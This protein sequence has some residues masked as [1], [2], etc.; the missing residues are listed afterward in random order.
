MDA[1]CKNGLKAT[2]V[3]S[4]RSRETDCIDDQARRMGVKER[5]F[6]NAE[7]VACGVYAWNGDASG[8]GG[9]TAGWDGGKEAF[10]I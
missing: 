6:K 5:V 1:G 7:S 8:C 2:D 10:K 3:L 4:A 9:R